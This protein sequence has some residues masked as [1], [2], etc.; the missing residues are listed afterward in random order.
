MSVPVQIRNRNLEMKESIT[1][2]SH[3]FIARNDNVIHGDH[4]RA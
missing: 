4:T 1:M 2:R 3:L